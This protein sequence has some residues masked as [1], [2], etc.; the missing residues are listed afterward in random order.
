MSFAW[1]CF[2]GLFTSSEVQWP[3]YLKFHDRAFQCF[4]WGFEMEEARVSLLGDSCEVDEEEPAI[5]TQVPLLAPIC[6]SIRSRTLAFSLEPQLPRS[7]WDHVE[8]DWLH[9]FVPNLSYL[10]LITSFINYSIFLPLL[11]FTLIFK[12]SFWVDWLQFF[13]TKSQLAYSY[14]KPHN[15]QKFPFLC[16]HSTIKF[17]TFSCTMTPSSFRAKPWI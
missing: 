10:T 8:W 17:T 15:M 6:R 4:I 9:F 2:G 13:C 1:W 3:G 5:S 7:T 12:I 11:T 16:S 14:H